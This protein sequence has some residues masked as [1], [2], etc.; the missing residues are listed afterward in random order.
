[1][2][3]ASHRPEIVGGSCEDMGEMRVDRS[4]ADD[5]LGWDL[6]LLIVICRYAEAYLYAK[7]AH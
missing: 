6:D 5:A 3:E 1:M 4:R 2:A 7:C